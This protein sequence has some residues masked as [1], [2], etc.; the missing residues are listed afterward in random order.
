MH[1][2][3]YFLESASSLCLKRRNYDSLVPDQFE[4]ACCIRSKSKE[5]N[6]FLYLVRCSG[7]NKTTKILKKS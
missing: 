7:Y 2:V 3:L 6:N 4:L 5:E 1:L